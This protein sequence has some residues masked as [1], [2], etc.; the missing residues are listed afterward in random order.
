MTLVTTEGD[1]VDR[2]ESEDSAEIDRSVEKSEQDKEN[3]AQQEFDALLAK[4]QNEKQRKSLF[5]QS[6]KTVRETVL[7][8]IGE[9]KQVGKS[10]NMDVTNKDFEIVKII[11]HGSFGK[12]YLVKKKDTEE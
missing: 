10:E 5:R 4:G 3:E 9:A 2:E 6:L 11:G 8:E 12:V 7:E 1:Y